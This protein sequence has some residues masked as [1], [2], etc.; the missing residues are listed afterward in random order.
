MVFEVLT[1]VNMKVSIF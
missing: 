1:A